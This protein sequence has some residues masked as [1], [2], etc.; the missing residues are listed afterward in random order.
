MKETYNTGEVVRF[1]GMVNQLGKL[2]PGL[3]EK[4]KSLRDLLSMINQFGV[5]SC[6]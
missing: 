3:T 1:L 6:A 2:I 5:W 4:D